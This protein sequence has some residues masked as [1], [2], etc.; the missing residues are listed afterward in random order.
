LSAVSKAVRNIENI[1]SRQQNIPEEKSVFGVSQKETT[2]EKT[3]TGDIPP[4]PSKSLLTKSGIPATEKKASSYTAVLNNLP[5]MSQTAKAIFN[6]LKGGNIWVTGGVVFITL[7]VVFAF[8]YI[9][10]NYYIPDEIKLAG[11]LLLGLVLFVFGW[12]QRFL[13]Q[14]F[15]LV[16]QGGGIGIIYLSF[17]ASVKIYKIFPVEIIFPLIVVLIFLSVALSVLQNSQVMALFATII[18]FAAPLLLSSGS[19]NYIVLFSYYTLLN[20]GILCISFKKYWRY[21]NAIGFIFT[22]TVLIVWGF[23][24]YQKAFFVNVEIFLV[25]FFLI[26]TAVNIISMLRQTGDRIENAFAVTTSFTFMLIQLNLTERFD[27]GQAIASFLLGLFYIVLT[28]FLGRRL[29]EKLKT[30]ITLYLAL[31]IIFVNMSAPMFFRGELSAGLWAAEGAV[32]VI[33]GVYQNNRF[34][35]YF[36]MIIALAAVISSWILHTTPFHTP[37]LDGVW[38]SR[39]LSACALL[40][41]SGALFRMNNRE[42]Y[43]LAPGF[44]LS[45]VI[46]WF[47]AFGGEFWSQGY[48]L[49]TAFLVLTPI[50]ALLFTLAGKTIKWELPQMSAILPTAYVMYL[51][52]PSLFTFFSS[53]F[54]FNYHLSYFKFF[55]L[56]YLWTNWRWVGWLAFF[57]TYAVLL[58]I[59]RDKESKLFCFVRASL[60][61]IFTL[62]CATNIQELSDYVFNKADITFF[63]YGA[64]GLLLTAAAAALFIRLKIFKMWETARIWGTGAIIL[65]LLMWVIES[66]Q[67]SMQANRLEILNLPFLNPTDNVII[68][69]M[70]ASIHWLLYTKYRSVLI[71]FLKDKEKILFPSIAVVFFY[72]LHC[73]IARAVCYYADGF[74]NI[75]WLFNS[76]AYQLSV[77]ILWGAVGFVIMLTG[78]KKHIRIYWTVGAVMLAVDALKLFLIDL[79]RV[80]TFPRIG[81][82]MALGFLFIIIGYFVPLPPKKEK[83]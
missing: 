67:Y 36:G 2:Q 65:Y 34:F 6:F 61:F 40:I 59:Y 13:R 74:Y 51:F 5:Q 71:P 15:A 83:I 18:G 80:G 72:W 1:L 48:G 39:F 49:E 25:I 76:G 3:V 16:L 47:A 79:S 12:R 21:L 10:K 44:F 35:R 73:A 62:S 82:F 32:L 8:T 14:T 27:Y 54:M 38:I 29:R 17:F 33:L 57:A 43:T 56:A 31:G 55:P 68:A 9:S 20:A 66:G 70:A 64:Q 81:S 19:G 30:L 63:F 41:S 22:F 53:I 26:Y 58:Y 24:N 46:M 4:I 37:F 23:Q 75:N 60:F 78:H 69:V 45:G 50:S 28:V 42:G 7:G 52:L 77:A 11:A